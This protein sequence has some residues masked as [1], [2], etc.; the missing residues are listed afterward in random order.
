[1]K[2]NIINLGKINPSYFSS[3]IELGLKA[4]H[5][6]MA[7]DTDAFCRLID[8]A[9][10]IGDHVLDLGCGDG[11]PT[12]QAIIRGAYHV[13]AVDNSTKAIQS[14]GSNWESWKKQVT[15]SHGTLEVKQADMLKILS[16]ENFGSN[17]IDIIISNP[18][19]IPVGELSARDTINGGPDGLNFIRP[20]LLCKISDKIA[21]LQGSLS[22]PI[23]VLRLIEI[24]HWEI[25]ALKI[26]ATHF[27][28]NAIR[29]Y[30]YLNTLRENE[31]SLFFTELG[32]NIHWFLK[33]GMICKKDFSNSF[34]SISAVES[35]KLLLYS[36]ERYGPFMFEEK[37][38]GLFFPFPIEYAIY[39]Q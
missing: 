9:I 13:I 35:L 3:F 18:P 32:V 8:C 37:S 21:W 26:F 16:A 11:I 12:I 27:G 20:L 10:N 7:E 30:K 1:M 34:P 14:I 29:Q 31:K 23:E 36:F 15:I 4:T 33:M 6:N 39:N 17:K 28:E 38:R 24:N 19:Y 2:N 5:F 22:D 25:T